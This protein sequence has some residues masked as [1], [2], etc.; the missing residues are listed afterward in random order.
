MRSYYSTTL[1]GPWLLLMVT[2]MTWLLF[3]R[4]LNTVVLLIAPVV[5][6]VVLFGSQDVFFERN[7]SPI[8]PAAVLMAG[9]G[10]TFL[11]DALLKTP[12][13]RFGFAIAVVLATS[14]TAGR[15]LQLFL[16]EG[17]EGDGVRM[18]AYRE[19]LSERYP[20]IHHTVAS[21]YDSREV[22]WIEDELAVGK[23]R[24][25]LSLYGFNDAY[26]ERWLPVLAARYQMLPIG[27]FRGT[28]A[29]YP[30]SAFKVFHGTRMQSYLLYPR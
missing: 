21:L 26:L 13:F 9:L 1:G 3:Q 7:L 14:V 19:S 11:V 20:D 25:L 12:K 23:G 16:G 8:A 2:G 6:S 28:F 17:I 22:A 5:C 10:I 18:Q 4:Q 27:E 30:P 15:T 24:I 29:D